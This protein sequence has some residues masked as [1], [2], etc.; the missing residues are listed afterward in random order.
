MIRL[1]RPDAETAEQLCRIEKA[2]F[3]ARARPWSAVDYVN[4]GAPPQAAILTD[5]DVA[6]GLLVLQFAADE[7]EILNLGVIPSARR[8]GLATA[9]LGEGI[10][11]ASSLGIARLFLEVAAT[12]APARVL[13]QRTGFEQVGTRRGYYRDPGGSRTDA[14]LMAK[15]L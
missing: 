8:S 13:Y 4:L 10:A 15:V 6:R 3:P 5:D 7:G 2:A 1:L 12:N 9:L 11:L 14:I